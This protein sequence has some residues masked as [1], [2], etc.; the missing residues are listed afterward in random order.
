MDIVGSDSVV[1]LA[2]CLLDDR[3][4]WNARPHLVVVPSSDEA[5]SLVQALQFFDPASSAEILSGFDVSPYSGLYPSRKLMAQRMGWLWKASHAK[6][7]QIFI[8]PIEALLQKT[9][10]YSEFSKRQM[11]LQKNELL[12]DNFAEILKS[13]G[14]TQTPIVE[15]VGTF[16]F[17]GGIVDV[18]SPAHEKPLRMELFGDVIDSARFFDPG[19]Q[20]SEEDCLRYEVIPPMEIQFTSESRQRVSKYF[21]QT[22]SE[23]VENPDEVQNIKQHL[24]LGAYQHGM[25]F[26]LAGFFE[27][28]DS[29]LDHFSSELNVWML[30][31]MACEKSG[32]E[33]FRN[34]KKDFELSENLVFHPRIEDLFV[35]VDELPYP[36]DSKTLSLSKIK[37]EEGAQEVEEHLKPALLPV[38]TGSLKEVANQI[39]NLSGNATD[40]SQFLGQKVSEWK[41]LK[42]TVVFALSTQSQAERIKLLLDRVGLTSTLIENNEPVPLDFIEREQQNVKGVHLM[43]RNL[44]ESF[45]LNEPGWIFLREADLFGR[46]S[47]KR[48]AS[49][50][51]VNEDSKAFALNFSDLKPGDLIVHK[52]HGVG[53]YEGLK[54]MPI[55]GVDAEFIQLKYKGN[56]RLYLP[57]YR[58]HQ[59]HKYSGPASP[60]LVDK[61]GGTSWEKT[62]TKVRSHLRDI[63]GELLEIYAKRKMAKRPS[64]GIPDADYRAFEAAFPYD[65]TEDQLKA[66]DDILS[67][68]QKDAPMDRLVCGDVGFGKTEVAMRA[69]FKVAQEGKQVAIIAPTT[70][71]TFQH[72][73]TFQKRFKGWPL[74]IR[75]LNRFV[76]RSEAKKTLEDLKEGRV[77]ILIGTHRLLSQ[78]VRFK[79]LGLLIID[80][81][82]RFGVKHKE[83]LR[84]MRAHLDT[85]AMSATPIPRTLNMSLVGVRDLS[86]INTPPV[87]RLPT[88]TFVCKFDRATIQKAVESELSRGGQVYF[89]HNRVQSIYALAEELKE[90]LPGVRMQVAHGQM[91]EGQLEKAMVA[92]FHH[93]IDLL[94]CTTIVESGMDVPRANTMFIDR[95]HQLGLSQLYQLRGRVGRSKERAYCY[96]LIPQNQKLDKDGQERLRIIQE[97]SALGSGIRIA[98]YDL[99]LRGAGDIL[100]ESQAGHINAVGYELYLELLEEAIHRARGEDVADVEIEPEINLRIPA[101]I[102]DQYISDLRIR[103]AYYKALAQIESPEDLDRIE[104]ELRDQFGKPPEPVINLMGLMLIRKQCRDL[105]VRD[106]SAGKVGLALAFTERTPLSPEKAIELTSRA[107]K[108]YGITPDSRLTVRMNEITWPRVAEE[109]DY[110]LKSV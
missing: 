82:Q 50:E 67:D 30:D 53:V 107:N 35:S 10:P 38:S 80:E 97:N 99:E 46:T 56:D 84:K 83:K 11:T 108:K 31:P 34:L 89:I 65:E 66:I 43:I 51:G 94:L 2:G 85:L 18:F 61:L 63:A 76:P 57:V 55:Q 23:D 100:G 24:S 9:L 79:D 103:L 22:L 92:F 14:Y 87:D 90:A 68:L 37:I 101:L 45:R 1:F 72:L 19:S 64:F 17:R 69:A 105:G 81:E 70:V 28:L 62:K 42:Q 95:S 58:I 27:S 98:Q 3:V 106:L 15:D 60:A 59:I 48:R 29:P 8:A 109:L 73:E 96:L 20:R 54:V 93:E 32:D 39:K 78:D 7:G 71:L 16:S 52:L 41:N 110:L 36:E 25:E 21:Q 26:L 91:E 12:S 47:K 77:D 88:R 74:V 104:E 75:S 13:W 4:R 44:P 33:F 49:K 5:D 86:L 40:L 102:P 6:A